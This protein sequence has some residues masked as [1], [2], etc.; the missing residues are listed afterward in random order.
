MKETK[1][2]GLH[3]RLADQECWHGVD[4]ARRQSTKTTVA[5]EGSTNLFDVSERMA[6]YERL[7]F[8]LVINSQIDEVIWESSLPVNSAEM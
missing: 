3:H 5:S 7:R 4:K 1:M 8:Y 2:I 6:C